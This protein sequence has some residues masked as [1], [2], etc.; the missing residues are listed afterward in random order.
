LLFLHAEIEVW[1]VKMHLMI[2][3]EMRKTI[4]KK[5]IEILFM[6]TKISN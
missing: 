2:L 4:N 1:S 5:E 3:A 6:D